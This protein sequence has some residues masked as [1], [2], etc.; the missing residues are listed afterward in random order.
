ML[1]SVPARPKIF[2][3]PHLDEAIS[4]FVLLFSIFLSDTV[5][6]ISPEGRHQRYLIEFRHASGIRG[7]HPGVPQVSP[8]L[9]DLGNVR[10]QPSNPRHQAAA[11][12]ATAFSFHCTV[13]FSVASSATVTLFSSIVSALSACCKLLACTSAFK[14]A[15]S[16]RLFGL[17]SRTALIL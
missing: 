9:Q 8:Q 4:L 13:T 16:R 5:G 3:V 17:A 15:D 6:A 10:P 1:V 7:V 14:V 2:Q 11:V 12:F